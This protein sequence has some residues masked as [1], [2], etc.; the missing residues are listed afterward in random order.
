MTS[1]ESSSET[2]ILE[3]AVVDSFENKEQ[4]VGRLAGIFLNIQAR[5]YIQDK[6][7]EQDVSDEL[8]DE[9]LGDEEKYSDFLKDYGNKENFERFLKEDVNIVGKNTQ[10]GELTDDLGE[11]IETYVAIGMIGE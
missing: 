4:N 3:S 2:D 5:A 6:L 7:P 9:V 1:S 11:L 10:D 8:I